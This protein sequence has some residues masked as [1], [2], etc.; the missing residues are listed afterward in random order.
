MKGCESISFICHGPSYCLEEIISL[1]LKCLR[2]TKS[3]FLIICNHEKTSVSGIT[4]NPR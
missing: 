4:A 3:T 1:N 2:L